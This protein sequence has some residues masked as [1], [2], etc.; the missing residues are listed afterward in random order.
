MDKNT[1]DAKRSS[2][3]HAQCSHL[4]NFITTFLLFSH[5]YCPLKYI[6]NVNNTCAISPLS[7]HIAIVRVLHNLT[8]KP[9]T[10][11]ARLA[12]H[13]RLSEPWN[14]NFTISSLRVGSKA[15]SNNGNLK[16]NPIY[17][18][19]R[20]TL[21]LSAQPSID[22]HFLHRS[23][24]ISVLFHHW[25][26]PRGTMNTLQ[27]PYSCWG[28]TFVCFSRFSAR[29][30]TCWAVSQW[31]LSCAARIR[32]FPPIFGGL[33]VFPWGLGRSRRVLIARPGA[34]PPLR[35]LPAA[36]RPD[37]TSL[38]TASETSPRRGCQLIRVLF[39]EC[40]LFAWLINGQ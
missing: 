6:Y 39:I 1:Y 10:I 16:V 14:Y 7:P 38:L 26:N 11:P 5:F 21:N 18:G 8:Q 29:A 36:T 15:S 2:F 32:V 3:A 31:H 24:R 33:R 37:Q 9:V 25:T 30:E 27:S 20:E 34:A 19:F 23:S 28:C 17:I 40:E 13:Y 4:D 12:N 22:T 35:P